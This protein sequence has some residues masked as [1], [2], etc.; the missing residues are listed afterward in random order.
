MSGSRGEAEELTRMC[1]VLPNDH[2]DRQ[3]AIFFN[4]NLRFLA[5]EPY[6]LEMRCADDETE[7][8]SDAFP[9]A[10]AVVAAATVRA[11]HS[12]MGTRE[13]PEAVHYPGRTSLHAAAE[14]LSDLQMHLIGAV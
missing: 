1:F 7:R 10:S 13:G 9:C 11:Q 2:S 14:A 6:A 5:A 3:C 8:Q 4:A 12:R